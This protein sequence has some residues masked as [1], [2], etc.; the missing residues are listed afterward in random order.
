LILAEQPALAVSH[1]AGQVSVSG[2]GFVL[3]V[4][5][6]SGRIGS[7][8]I[9][10]REL[11]SAGPAL[12]LWRAPTDNDANTWGDQRA[13]I[14]W[15]DSGL[16]QLQ[17]YVDGVD[18]EQVSAQEV[19]I[20]VRTAS[21]AQIDVVA[22]Q[23]ERWA[24]MLGEVKALLVHGIDDEQAQLLV[25]ALGI[26]YTEVAGNDRRAK[27]AA[28]VDLLDGQE[29]VPDLFAILHSAAEGPMGESLPEQVKE[30]LAAAIG[31][32]Q[33]DLKADLGASGSARFDIEYTY[34]ILGSGDILIETHLLPSGALPPT[35]PRVGLTMA[36][37]GDFETFTWYGR[38][39]HESYVDRKLSAPVGLYQGSVEDQYYAPYMMPQES[40]NKTDVRWVALT[41]EDGV[42]LLVTGMPEMGVSAHHFTA[43]ELT[44]ATHTFDLEPRDEVILNLDHAQTGLGNGSCG[45]GVLPEYQ[46]IPG[47]V[48]FSVRLRPL[49]VYS[50]PPVEEA[51]T[52]I[53][54]G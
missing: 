42:G 12:N 20:T 14:R 32:S 22:Q 38:G 28:M 54:Q 46:L 24:Q 31:K 36:L 18:V 6:E 1:D 47:E 10:D 51:K 40:G 52:R 41:D 2:Q 21:F 5:T 26:D 39:P 25:Q 33:D 9:S 23:E 19:R 35:L 48:R 50:K 37:P 11:I 3:K 44:E 4:D 45:P 7:L 16:D 17:E 30:R 15:R 29:R 34:R 53:D 49:G 27:M 13:A 8:Q 43:Q